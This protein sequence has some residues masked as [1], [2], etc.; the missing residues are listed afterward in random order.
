VAAE[1]SL[2]AL[3][4][5]YGIQAYNKSNLGTLVNS[6]ASSSNHY[7]ALDAAA[8]QR[9]RD[10]APNAQE[11][12]IARKE[13]TPTK[14]EP[15]DTLKAAG[16]SRVDLKTGREGS[17]I[18]INPNADAA[19]YAHELGHGISQKT[20][21]GRFINNARHITRN[22]PA[23]AK[24]LHHALP[25]ALAVGGAALQEG[26]DDLVASL[27]IAAAAGAPRLIDEGLATKNALAI[28]DSAGMRANLGQRGR[29]AG[30]YL[31][32]L[33]PLIIAG[34]VGNTV[35]NYADDYTALYDL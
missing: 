34:S 29:L 6:P 33:A 26:D 8:K 16:H 25:A 11:L 10:I 9:V 2:P 27:A 1:V 30:G 15:F 24:A 14:D 21:A 17:L 4:A 28:M 31:S 22:N 3:L 23:L 18:Q 19:Y 20:D 12:L 32:Y 5:A 13:Y 7:D 35:G